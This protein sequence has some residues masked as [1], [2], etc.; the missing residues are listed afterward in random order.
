MGMDPCR[1]DYFPSEGSLLGR[2]SVLWVGSLDLVDG[3][4]PHGG[5]G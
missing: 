1:L 3:I 5:S 4:E 2:C